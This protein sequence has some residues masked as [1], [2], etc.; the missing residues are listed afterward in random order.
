MCHTGPHTAWDACSQPRG[1]MAASGH[2]DRHLPCVTILQR[3][4]HTRLSDT[5]MTDSP[6]SPVEGD[7]ISGG[8][9][10][11]AP[12]TP[13]G[14]AAVSG[15]SA[16]GSS[17]DADGAATP[18]ADDGAATADGGAGLSPDGS[19]DTPIDWEARAAEDHRSRAQLL[20]ALVSAEVQGNAWLDQLRRK[21]A[22]FDNFRKR[23]A[24]DA[25]RQREVGKEAIARS[26]LE[27][28][29]DFDR[30]V[31][32]LDA[33]EATRKG[34]ELVHD[35]LVTALQGQG[36]TRMEAAGTPFDPTLHE[37]VQ[38]VPGEVGEPTVAEVYRT[39]WMMH[40]RVLR[41]AMVVVA[42]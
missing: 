11:D 14:H 9:F 35:K 20:E 29:D 1:G 24:R 21:Q 37:A 6:N 36:L 22:E 26:L 7:T 27:V 4:S 40:D 8:P 12:I 25:Q 15:S 30:T 17:A 5:S 28:M 3:P 23:M 16:G 38:Q 13:D 18:T 33:D 32:A 2:H 39:G 34:V 10:T 41:A 19:E 31:A 42:Q